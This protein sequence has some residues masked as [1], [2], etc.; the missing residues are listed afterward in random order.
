MSR[1]MIWISGKPVRTRFLR[2][3]QPMPPA[4][5]SNILDWVWFVSESSNTQNQSTNLSYL[6]KQIDTERLTS[7]PISRIDSVHGDAS[8]R[9]RSEAKACITKHVE[10]E[11]NGGNQSEGLKSGEEKVKLVNEEVQ[12][13]DNR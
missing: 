5:T 2:S 8:L 7:V 6:E 11:G 12:A 1:S 9:S 13:K 3:S 10:I 4:P